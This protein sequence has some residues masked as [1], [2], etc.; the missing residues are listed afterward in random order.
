MNPWIAF[1]LGVLVGVIGIVVFA[2]RAGRKSPAH[3]SEPDPANDLIGL[4]T[5][6]LYKMGRNPG[7]HA[8]VMYL[9]RWM[10]GRGYTPLSD[11]AEIAKMVQ[12]EE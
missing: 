3:K 4:A 10:H 7:D 9:A 12:N 2:A 1:L 6:V 8:T 5:E 11:P